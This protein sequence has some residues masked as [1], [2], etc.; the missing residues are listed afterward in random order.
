MKDNNLRSKHFLSLGVICALLFWLADA[1]ID[2]LLFREKDSLMASLLQPEP[3]ELWM[4]CFVVVMFVLFSLYAGRVYQRQV[5]L[6]VELEQY[7]NEL[8]QRVAEKTQHLQRSYDDLVRVTRE[9][10]TLQGI[11]PICSYCRKIRDDD[12]A[13]EGLETYIREHSNATFSHGVCPGCFAKE[14]MK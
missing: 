2:Y 1:L 6:N 11:I 3:V 7:K 9:V 4:R 13:W 12:G 10:K 5:S 14:S 8:E